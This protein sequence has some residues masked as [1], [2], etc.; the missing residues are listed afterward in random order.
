MKEFTKGIIT[1]NPVLVI[2]LGLCPSLAVS[3]SVI[4]AVGMGTAATFVLL[5]SNLIIS[6]MRDL[7]P[8]QIR[9]PV[10]VVIIATFV[11]IIDKVIAAF[12]P[13]LSDSLGIFIP[14]IVVNCIIL[15]R[16]EAFASKNTPTASI[17]DALGM[18]LGFTLAL[19]I[20]AFFREVL[21]D[22]KLAGIKLYQTD[23]ALI[24]IMAPGGFF[25]FGL[26]MGLKKHLERK[27]AKP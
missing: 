23:P 7:V 21:G 26:L 16:A 18:G 5:G 19:I 8:K 17:F 22:G 3:T 25:V 14:L 15:G 12:F 2:M 1:E 4:N 11:T 24:M 10:Y 9:I 20:I 6:F 13:S 27:G